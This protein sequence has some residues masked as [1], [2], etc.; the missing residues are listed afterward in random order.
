DGRGAAPVR[1]DLPAGAERPVAVLRPGDD[2]R[3]DRLPH[4]PGPLA[5]TWRAGGVSLLFRRPNKG[6][7]PLARRR[8]VHHVGAA[9]V[10]VRGGPDRC[11]AA[12]GDPCGGARA[13]PRRRG[14]LGQPCQHGALTLP[15][16][17]HHLGFW[18][19]AARILRPPPPR[20][21]P[22]DVDTG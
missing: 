16:G 7:T 3:S 21:Q 11:A 5:V 6:L 13:A 14:P 22:G 15:F 17:G 9:A 18:V 10:I 8:E 20:L 12:L 19:R 1:L 4:R 2:A